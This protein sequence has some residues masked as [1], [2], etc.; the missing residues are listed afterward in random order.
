[1]AP[2]NHDDISFPSVNQVP[3]TAT[4]G[5]LP[6]EKNFIHDSNYYRARWQIE[7]VQPHGLTSTLLLTRV[8]GSN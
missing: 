5:R 3:A 4:S 8:I 1:M 7:D 2:Y 6:L